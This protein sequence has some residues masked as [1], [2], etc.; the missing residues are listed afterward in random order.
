M[1]RDAVKGTELWKKEVGPEFKNRFGNGPR[2]TPTI[3]G[4]RVYVQSV[5]GPLVC[6]EAASGKIF[7]NVDILKAFE[8]KNITWGLSA[9]PLVD[10]D[11]VYAIPGAAGAGV[12]A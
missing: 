11:L 1:A 10:G 5:S 6:L 8:G 9:S 4:P 2:S 3:D 12:V 7:W